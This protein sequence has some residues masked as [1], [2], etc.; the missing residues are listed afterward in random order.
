MGPGFLGV[1][2]PSAPIRLLQ[3]GGSGLFANWLSD[4]QLDGVE[5]VEGAGF[6]PA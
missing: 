5:L 3:K 2:L 6:E 4:V 1:V